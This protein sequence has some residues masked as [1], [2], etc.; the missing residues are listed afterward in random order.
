MSKPEE[1]ERSE[2]HHLA[3]YR[4]LPRTFKPGRPAKDPPRELVWEKR[5]VAHEALDALESLFTADLG[6]NC[7]Y[8]R[9]GIPLHFGPRMSEKREKVEVQGYFTSQTPPASD[10]FDCI[11]KGNVS[12]EAL[13]TLTTVS[14]SEAVRF[15]LDV[16]WDTYCRVVQAQEDLIARGQRHLE[17]TMKQQEWFISLL[18]KISELELEVRAINA[19]EKVKDAE[20]ARMRAES[21]AHAQAQARAS[22]GPKINIQDIFEALR[23]LMDMARPQRPRD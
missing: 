5:D 1:V 11:S 4:V 21:D 23:D 14:P 6:P 2:R 12:P 9:D 13:A 16:L 3:I 19:E 20:R 10:L 17:Q 18:Q 7:V 22:A 8:E 15:S